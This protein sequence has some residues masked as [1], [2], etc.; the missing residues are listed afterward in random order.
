M[1]FYE[2]IIFFTKIALC[3]LSLSASAMDFSEYRF[4]TNPEL[5]KKIHDN[6]ELIDEAFCWTNDPEVN[7][8]AMDQLSEIF[9][10]N[11][12]SEIQEALKTFLTIRP[13]EF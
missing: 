7:S 3:S 2:D 1:K 8:K 13:K 10:E 12:M 9:T 5:D 4:S 11:Q 6:I